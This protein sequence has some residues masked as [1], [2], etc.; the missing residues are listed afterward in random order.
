MNVLTTDNGSEFT[1]TAI[2]KLL[3][4]N[5]IEHYLNEPEDHSTMGM[6]ER[7]NRTLKQKLE[8]IFASK[9]TV[10]SNREPIIE[11]VGGFNKQLVN[12]RGW[13]YPNSKIS[14]FGSNYLSISKDD[15]MNNDARHHVYPFGCLKPMMSL[16]LIGKSR[17]WLKFDS[18]S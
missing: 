13:F 1:N 8:K 14:R 17:K 16:C 18:T 2:K 15:M 9:D 5:D 4:D 6:I 10:N 7:F 11:E 12:V 3:K